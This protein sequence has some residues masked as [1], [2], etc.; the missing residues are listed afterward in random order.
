[1]SYKGWP[2]STLTPQ[3]AAPFPLQGSTDLL[4]QLSPSSGF[5]FQDRIAVL[6]SM[7]EEDPCRTQHSTFSFA[8]LGCS[9]RFGASW[10]I[11]G[12]YSVHKQV[13]GKKGIGIP[14]FSWLVWQTQH[15]VLRKTGN[16]ALACQARSAFVQNW[17]S[18]FW[19][20]IL[21]NNDRVGKSSALNSDG[22]GGQAFLLPSYLTP[23]S[24]HILNPIPGA[25]SPTLSTFWPSFRGF[26][27]LLSLV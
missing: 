25:V 4:E 12:D 23:Q 16:A 7:A 1:M 15:L 26:P 10:A 8:S 24:S 9:N 19:H 21:T 14:T 2:V 18:E 5:F 13:V 22:F 3:A 20:E 6:V 11:W 27:P 17:S